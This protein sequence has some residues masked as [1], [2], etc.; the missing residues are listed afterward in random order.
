MNYEYLTDTADA[1]LAVPVQGESLAEHPFNFLEIRSITHLT[2]KAADSCIEGIQG[3][4]SF[5]SVFDN[6]SLWPHSKKAHDVLS[7]LLLGTLMKHH[8]N[9]FAINNAQRDFYNQIRSIVTPGEASFD[10]ATVHAHLK[11]LEHVGFS[12]ELLEG[13]SPH[14]IALLQAGGP[15]QEASA[16]YANAL[17]NSLLFY[18]YVVANLFGGNS[19]ESLASVHR[20]HE[21]VNACF[22]D[23][24]DRTYRQPA[25]TKAP[26]NA[27]GTVEAAPEAAVGLKDLL[28]ELDSMI[29]LEPVKEEVRTLTNLMRMQAIRRERG[30]PVTPMTNSLVF[31]GPPG[32]GKTTVARLLSRIYKALGVLSK[33]HLVEVDRSS[34]VGGYVGQ[35]AIQTR[36]KIEEALGGVLFIDEA[37]ALSPANSSN[38]YGQ[39]AINTLLKAMEDHRANLVVIVAGYSNKMAGFI[40]SNPGL[41]S[42]FNK[43]VEFPDYDADELTR[44]FTLFC[45][46]AHYTLTGEAEAHAQHLFQHLHATRGEHFG[47]A[48]TARNIFERTLTNQ[49]T[50]VVK[51]VDIT[52]RDLT[53]ITHEDLPSTPQ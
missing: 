38:D 45:K 25:Q 37:Y 46:Q 2:P 14:A 48:R 7:A 9:N 47:N 51:L 19:P 5:Q 52:D 31:Q 17:Q 41:R 18:S 39:E 42:R 50:R 40:D 32:T 11:K 30:L 28:E 8:V 21:N 53:T 12:D 36:E 43:Y 16:E 20:Q 15:N 23:Y 24:I 3:I 26:H 4:Y 13:V 1:E 35:T 49:A 22:T 29:G 10:N 34:L 44:I 33:G 27:V 6:S